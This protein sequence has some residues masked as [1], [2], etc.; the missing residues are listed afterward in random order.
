MEVT[1]CERGHLRYD[2]PM[3]RKE[4]ALAEIVAEVQ[5]MPEDA[6]WEFVSDH[7]RLVLSIEKSRVDARTGKPATAAEL[8]ELQGEER[9][10]F[11]AAIDEAQAQLSR[12]E[13]IPH[14]EVKRQAKS[15]FQK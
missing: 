10:R 15:W 14:D 5:S 4:L 7:L 1:A 2:F 13:G 8:P 9:T 11:L 3:S 6:N 12:G